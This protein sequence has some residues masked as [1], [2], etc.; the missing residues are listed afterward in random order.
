MLRGMRYG[1]L[2]PLLLIACNDP[3]P[4]PSAASAKASASS[5]ATA[6]PKATLAPVTKPNPLDLAA[7]KKAF[8]CSGKASSGPCPV[9]EKFEKCREKWSPITQSGDGRWI[10]NGSVAKKGKYVEEMYMMRSRRVGLNEVAPGALGVK[11][12][13]TELPADDANLRTSAGKTWRKLNRGDSPKKGMHAVE[14]I[15]DHQDWPEAYAQQADAHQIYIAAGAGAYLCGD[16]TS[17]ALHAVKLS[18][19]QEHPGDGI[20]VTLYPTKW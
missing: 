15:N 1:V 13:L 4:A 14:F 7:L 19:S 3:T 11:I 12:A 10:G 17:Q 20:Y 6:K 18:G 8:N 9:L 5:T 2:I 16:P